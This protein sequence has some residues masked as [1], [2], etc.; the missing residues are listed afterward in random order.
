M[1]TKKRLYDLYGMGFFLNCTGLQDL[2]N[3]MINLGFDSSKLCSL[4]MVV[5]DKSKVNDQDSIKYGP[6]RIWDVKE[7]QNVRITRPNNGFSAMNDALKGVA[8][9]DAVFQDT[10]GVTRQVAAGA[11]LPGSPGGGGSD[12]TLGIY[13]Y[14]LQMADQRFLDQARFIEDDFGYP[15]LHFVLDCI[16]DPALISQEYINEIL[17]FKEVPEKTPDSKDANGMI[18]PGQPT[19]VVNRIPLLNQQELID[20]LNELKKKDKSADLDFAMIGLTQFIEKINQLKKLDDLIVRGTTNQSFA[21]YTNM[22]K[23][24]K[25]WFQ[26]SELPN[27]EELYN[28]NSPA[29]PP[30][31]SIGPNG[32]IPQNPVAPVVPPKSN[33]IPPVQAPGM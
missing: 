22:N 27:W 12:N 25:R 7:P 14:Q 8:Y 4:D 13:Q 11:T 30:P 6:T 10:T 32:V 28:E 29:V 17:G 1:R 26:L 18:V 16:L 15:L 23:T 9:I 24:V 21:P 3:S 31:P 20:T 5:I 19:G 33:I 2:G